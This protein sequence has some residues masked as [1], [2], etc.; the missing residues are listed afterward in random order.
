MNINFIDQ[1]AGVFTVKYLVGEDLPGREVGRSRPLANTRTHHILETGRTLVR[2]DVTTD[3][4][5]Q[6]LPAGNR[7]NL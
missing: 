1:E 5:L 7:G 2:A 4:Q 3:N 6:G